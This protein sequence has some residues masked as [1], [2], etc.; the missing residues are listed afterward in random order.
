MPS[1]TDLMERQRYPW[2]IDEDV[3]ALWSQQ[4]SQAGKKT[5]NTAAIEQ[6]ARR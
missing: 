3:I 6:T 1:I 5:G 2:H 4:S